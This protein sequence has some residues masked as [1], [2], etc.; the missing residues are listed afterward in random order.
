MLGEGEVADVLRN[1]CFFRYQ[2]AVK[3]VKIVKNVEIYG[4]HR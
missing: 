2:S 1:K 4:K 3:I